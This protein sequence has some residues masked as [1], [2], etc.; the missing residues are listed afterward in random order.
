MADT[1]LR[2]SETTPCKDCGNLGIVYTHWGPLVPSN[3]PGSFC[4]ECWSKRAN[5]Y[6]EHGKPLPYKESHVPEIS[7]NTAPAVERR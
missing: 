5:Y 3:D 4:G 1:M 2:E 6:N 7:P